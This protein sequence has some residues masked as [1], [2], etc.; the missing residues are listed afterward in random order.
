M[1]ETINT[2][3]NVEK[4]FDKTATPAQ[5]FMKITRC[6]ADQPCKEIQP[7]D[8]RE[9]FETEYKK[10]MTWTNRNGGI[11]LQE[12][13]ETAKATNKKYSDKDI[14]VAFIEAKTSEIEQWREAAI[15]EYRT[16]YKLSQDD[17]ED[18]RYELFIVPSQT[19]TEAFLDY[20]CGQYFISEE[21][22]EKYKKVHSNE[23]NV[24]TLFKLI[25]ESMS[26][27]L[28]AKEKGV[29][30][31]PIEITIFRTTNRIDDY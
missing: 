19:N 25:N 17:F 26:P 3:D 16:K 24:P 7:S 2:R 22:A 14:K 20:L 30:D 21:N 18:T 15:E 9:Y 27:E 10:D 1:G 29:V 31:Y 4:H 5:V 13:T 28:R 12:F 11:T 6:I 23:T 8:F